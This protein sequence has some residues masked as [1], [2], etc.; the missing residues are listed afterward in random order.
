MLHAN[1]MER[2]RSSYSDFFNRQNKHN[3]KEIVFYILSGR[4]PA[5]RVLPAT[6]SVQQLFQSIECSWM[7]RSQ[8]RVNGIR[9]QGVDAYLATLSL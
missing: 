9:M 4:L 3:G 8:Q 6:P 2:G 5:N 1:R 7:R